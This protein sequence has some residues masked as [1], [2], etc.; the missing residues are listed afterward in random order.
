MN[1]F[2]LSPDGRTF[3]CRVTEQ[4]VQAEA[5]HW[6]IT[7]IDGPPGEGINA[8]LEEQPQPF[9]ITLFAGERIDGGFGAEVQSW[10]QDLSSDQA[11]IVVE[12]LYSGWRTGSDDRGY[13]GNVKPMAEVL[14]FGVKRR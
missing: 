8:I 14:L 9:F 5:P 7:I 2:I 10:I 4:D 3:P 1:V 12:S 13:K 11:G 6:T